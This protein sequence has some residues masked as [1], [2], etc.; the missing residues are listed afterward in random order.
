MYPNVRVILTEERNHTLQNLLHEG[1]VDLAIARFQK[2]LPGIEVQ[3]F[4]TEDTVLLVSRQ[5]LQTCG[6]DLA[7]HRAEIERGDYVQPMKDLMA[8]PLDELK[9]MYNNREIEK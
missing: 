8:K 3:P 1:R 7:A 9:T 2:P 4:Y 5:L 6:I